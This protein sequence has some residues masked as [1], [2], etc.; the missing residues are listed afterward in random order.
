MAF[1]VYQSSE[2]GDTLLRLK[3]DGYGVELQVVDRDGEFMYTILNLNEDGTISLW[4][5]GDWGAEDGFDI[6]DGNVTTLKE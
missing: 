4:D 3:D 5:I 6:E 2:D 1:K